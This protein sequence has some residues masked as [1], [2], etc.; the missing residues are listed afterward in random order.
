MPME[1]PQVELPLREGTRL[2]LYT[3]GLVERRARPLDEGFAE[4]LGHAARLRQAPLAELVHAVVSQMLVDQES[5]DDV[6][7]L[8]LQVSSASPL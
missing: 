6:C 7:V 3:D 8:A 1:R 5:P 4:L 2:V